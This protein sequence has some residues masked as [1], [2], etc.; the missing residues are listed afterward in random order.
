MKQV[1]KGV[2]TFSSFGDHAIPTIIPAVG[3]GDYSVSV[4]KPAK[5][6][7]AMNSLLRGNDANLRWALHIDRFRV[8]LHCP[9]RTA[10]CGP[11]AGG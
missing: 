6:S 5:T 4:P 3:T 9:Y 1:R 7:A 8:E 11:F 2:S 10:Y